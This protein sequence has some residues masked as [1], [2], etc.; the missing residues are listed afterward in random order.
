MR[1]AIY[2][3]ISFIIASA[4]FA[5]ASPL[6]S[7]IPLRA[8]AA[9]EDIN[10]AYRSQ[11]E[12]SNY[13]KSTGGI[14][15]TTPTYTVEPSLKIPYE[16]GR[17]SKDVLKRA[18][19]T[20]NQVRYVAGL[21][22]VTLDS[23]YVEQ[24]QAGALTMAV[25]GELSHNP[26]RPLGMNRRMFDKQANGKSNIS[27]GFKTLEQAILEGFMA[28]SDKS[29]IDRLGHRR[30]V[31]NPSMGKTGFGYVNSF[32]SMYAFD[33]SAVT[34][35]HGVSWPA[36]NTPLEV[37]KYYHPWSVSVS[38]SLEETRVT[39]TRQSDGK[40]WRFY[41]G[42]TDGYFNYNSAG[43]GEKQ[44]IIFKPAEITYSPGD[45][46]RVE[47]TGPASV[48]YTVNFFELNNPQPEKLTQKQITQ[49]TK[50][51][52]TTE[53]Q[54]ETTAPQTTSA[55]TTT[56]APAT[57]A[58]ETVTE[59]ATTAAETT[60]SKTSSETAAAVSTTVTQTVTTEE[61][62][63]AQ[64]TQPSTATPEEL[65]PTVTDYSETESVYYTETTESVPDTTQIETTADSRNLSGSRLKIT[66][67]VAGAVI[68][69]IV[70]GASAFGIKKKRND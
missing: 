54:T 25:N 41:K 52:T 31:L 61:S 48:T 51:V 23:S 43:Y 26:K 12:I 38:G 6:L 36:A 35:Y 70:A 18:L 42:C 58:T 47:I 15:Y 46:F 11:R 32:S 33:T 1:K 19:A 64:T 3:I 40:V 7:A 59:T 10:V 22:P 66:V 28:D 5:G 17:L 57:T 53:K 68:V 62:T 14:T 55:V 56:T 63:T 60:V 24:C 49:A 65:I 67:A 50:P 20:V 13:F 34:S 69:A 8:D 37:F 29:N 30:W 27:R 39:L 2:K 9:V 44:C 21:D 16:P 45:S 4:V